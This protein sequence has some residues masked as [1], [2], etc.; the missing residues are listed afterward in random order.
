[1]SPA[2]HLAVALMLATAASAGHGQRAAAQTPQAAE[3]TLTPG[4]EMTGD[5]ETLPA[6]FRFA[7]AD[8][9]AMELRLTQ[10]GVDLEMR[11]VDASE[12]EVMSVNV[13]HHAQGDER[14]I[15]TAPPGSYV[16]SIIRAGSAPAAATIRFSL[17]AS[18]RRATG[19]DR[20]WSDGA[21]AFANGLTQQGGGT[22]DAL[23]TALASFEAAR[24]AW[25]AAG[26]TL[27]AATA[28]SGMALMQILLSQLQDAVATGEAALAL[29]RAVGDRYGEG[30]TLSDLASTFFR[31]GDHSRS[32]ELYDQAVAL[33]R[34]VDDP[35]GLGYSLMGLAVTRSRAVA[36]WLHAAATYQEALE[37]FERAGDRSGQSAALYNLG[38]A[39]K[40]RNDF[41]AALGYFER[42][43]TVRRSLNDLSG[44]AS[45]LTQVAA[46]HLRLGDAERALEVTEDAVALRRQSGDRRG[47]AY[48]V[49]TA[50]MALT[51]LGQLDPA[52]ERLTAALALAEAVGDRE[53]QSNVLTHMARLRVMTGAPAGALALT[54]RAHAVAQGQDTFDA[55][56]L[57]SVAGDAHLALGDRPQAAAAYTR[58]LAIAERL[59]ESLP[60]AEAL[61][62]LGRVARGNGDLLASRGHLLEAVD[63]IESIRAGVAQ[64]EL[65]ALFLGVTQSTYEAAIDTLVALHH[66]QP[67]AGYAAE[68]LALSERRRARVLVELL[69]EAQTDLRAGADRTLLDSEDAIQRRLNARAAARAAA[70]G[71]D[72]TSADR[73]ISDLVAELRAARADIRRH[74]PGYAAVTYPPDL[75]VAGVQKLLDARTLLLE[76]SLGEPQSYLWAITPTTMTLHVLPGRQRIEDAVRRARELIAGSARR[77][78]RGSLQRALAD[79]S[80]MLLGGVS[81][82]LPGHRLAIV[83]DG[84]L[85]F[86]PFA[87]L[88]RPYGDRDAP[89]IVDHEVVMLPSAAV[90]H[91]LRQ[92]RNRTRGTKTI[93]VIADPVLQREDP[94]LSPRSSSNGVP[95]DSRG[96]G[97]A[98]LAYAG[99]E[100]KAIGAKARGDSLMALG[101]DATRDLVVSAPLRDFRMVHL[102]T[103][104][105]VDTRHPELTG[106][107]LTLFDRGGAPVDGFLRLHDIFNLRLGASTVVLSAC[108]TAL[109][110]EIRGEGLVG[111][112]RGFMHAGASQ[113]VASLWNVND[114]ATAALMTEFYS[115]VFDRRLSPAAALR[116]AQIALWRDPR[117][118]M[119]V[120]WSGFT[121]QGDWRRGQTP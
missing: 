31:L 119:P 25:S 58:G 104:A 71:A 23:R 64:S 95:A 114:R 100:A 52:L 49:L 1:M 96:T 101:F 56:V 20:R 111:L 115:G 4:V 34:T 24:D 11:L 107:V 113:L 32:A 12:A 50:G 35:A 47:E 74:D 77:G 76:Y 79:L 62:G 75:D 13:R 82:Q 83:A 53:A 81:G 14:L 68:A 55:T 33:R 42:A 67:S 37:L 92:E 40:Q 72:R 108:E 86:V 43:L 5:V 44:Q 70:T 2:R 8:D 19:A 26:G 45:V 85:Q 46:I 30:K 65:R 36:G 61:A 51:R 54:E 90:L 63:R 117:W 66:Q 3:A 89:L 15:A 28:V 121:V 110:T 29:W 116:A 118:R 98:R 87:A 41:A 80:A 6:R 17:A 60:A 84:A 38:Y 59:G 106:I 57:A 7:L 105:V 120:Y 112:T 73:E 78:V 109:G 93:A 99:E 48:S 103:H 10:P 88:P 27:E 102:A 94:R 16:V 9:E 69:A 22:G 91:E 39:C 18:R 21:R 97:F